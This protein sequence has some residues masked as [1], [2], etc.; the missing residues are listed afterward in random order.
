MEVGVGY[1]EFGEEFGRDLGSYL[2]VFCFEWGGIGS[3]CFLSR[4]L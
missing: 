1:R 2:N 4:S 3:E